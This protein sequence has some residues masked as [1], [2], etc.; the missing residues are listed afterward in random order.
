MDESNVGLLISIFPFLINHFEIVSDHFNTLN[1]RVSPIEV[2]LGYR[3]SFVPL[4]IAN[5]DISWCRL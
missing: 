1:V 3:Y 4:F 2:F 5:R